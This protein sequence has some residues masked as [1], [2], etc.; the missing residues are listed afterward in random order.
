MVAGLLG[1]IW[2]YMAVVGMYELVRRKGDWDRGRK[3]ADQ[4]LLAGTIA[5]ATGLMIS[6]AVHETM[7]ALAILPALS[8]IKQAGDGHE[9]RMLSWI[10]AGVLLIGIGVGVWF[11]TDGVIG[12]V[13]LQKITE[14]P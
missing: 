7:P 9:G 12:G 3:H 5:V 8:A 11:Y 1:A 10:H 13:I 14:M 6:G 2:A 4:H